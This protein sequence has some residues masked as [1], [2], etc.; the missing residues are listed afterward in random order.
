MFKPIVCKANT[1]ITRPYSGTIKEK[2][3]DTQEKSKKIL[4]ASNREKGIK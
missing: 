2:L 3:E 4:F 1:N